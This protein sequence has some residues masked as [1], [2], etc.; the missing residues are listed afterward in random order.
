MKLNDSAYAEVIRAEEIC[1][2]HHCG[3]I[4][5]IEPATAEA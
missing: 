5:Y 4:L 1:T 3:R 2:C